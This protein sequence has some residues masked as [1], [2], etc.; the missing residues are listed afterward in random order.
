VNTSVPVVPG[1]AA[2]VWS[3]V[4]SVA[5][6]VTTVYD[7]FLSAIVGVLPPNVIVARL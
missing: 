2:I 3:V 1:A 5:V 4:I 7:W 6:W